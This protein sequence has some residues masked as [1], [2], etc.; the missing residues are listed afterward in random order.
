MARHSE[1]N[2]A[3]QSSETSVRCCLPIGQVTQLYGNLEFRTSAM[4]LSVVASLARDFQTAGSPTRHAQLPSARPG[5]F[6]RPSLPSRITSCMAHS[7]EHARGFD[8]GD[9]C[10]DASVRCTAFTL[11]LLDVLG[12]NLSTSDHTEGAGS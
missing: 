3:G 10:A 6:M 9:A 5:R 1:S 7:R 11:G 4:D 8:C 12:G 2:I